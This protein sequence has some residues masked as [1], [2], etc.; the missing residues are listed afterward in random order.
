MISIMLFKVDFMILERQETDYFFCVNALYW[1][2]EYL[3][4]NDAEKK[5]IEIISCYQRKINLSIVYLS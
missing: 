2:I 4:Y 3:K 5:A 1:T